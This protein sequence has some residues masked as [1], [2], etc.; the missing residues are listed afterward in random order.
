MKNYLWAFIAGGIA[1]G[2]VL[3]DYGRALYPLMTAFLFALMFFSALDVRVSNIFSAA[4]DL[5]AVSLVLV[6]NYAFAPLVALLLGAF[7]EKEFLAGLMI[8]AAAPSATALPFLTRL[9]GGDSARATAFTVISN[10]LS[11]FLMP[12]AILLA[13]GKSVQ[14]DAVGLASTMTL[15]VLLPLAIGLGIGKTGIGKKLSIHGDNAST[16]IIGVLFWALTSNAAPKLS[17][18]IGFAAVFFASIILS[19]ACFATGFMAGKNREDKATLAL[20]FFKK[21]G[22]LATAIAASFFSAQATLATIVFIF[23]SNLFY[24]PAQYF[25]QR[26]NK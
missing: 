7:L 2:F 20:A 6:A 24:L 25:L 11:P 10:F 4:K 23:A 14:V 8:S 18:S 22:I 13:L 3:P 1:L 17:I 15:V 21:N 5:R 12:L 26:Y 19:A 16:I 9:F